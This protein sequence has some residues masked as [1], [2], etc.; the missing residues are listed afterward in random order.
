M[1]K[2]VT[3]DSRVASIKGREAQSLRDQANA[4]HGYDVAN[5]EVV[6]AATALHEEFGVDSIQEAQELLGK[7]HAE[8]MAA[9]AEVEKL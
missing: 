4:Q 9:V 2:E 5:S 3:L 8:A 7:L 1:N 6:R